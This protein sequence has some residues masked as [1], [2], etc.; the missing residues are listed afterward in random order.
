MNESEYAGFAVEGV[1]DSQ[2]FRHLIFRR[3][4][5]FHGFKEKRV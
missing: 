3:K 2:S 4:K 5:E 1:H